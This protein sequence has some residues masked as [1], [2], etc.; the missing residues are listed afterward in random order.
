MPSWG[1][2]PGRACTSAPSPASTRGTWWIGD[3]PVS[4]F[5]PGISIEDNAAVL[6]TYGSGAFLTYP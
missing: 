3:T 4:V 2:A 5:S 6:V 1:P